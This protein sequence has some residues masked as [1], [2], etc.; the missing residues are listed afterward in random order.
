MKQLQYLC[1]VDFVVHKD[2]FEGFG[3]EMLWQ[4][5]FFPWNAPVPRR[6]R[7]LRGIDALLG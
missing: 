7:S 4:C 6:V 2:Y 1:V 3:E 5:S